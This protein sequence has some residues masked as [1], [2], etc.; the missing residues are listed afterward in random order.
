[1][2]KQCSHSGEHT[3]VVTEWLSHSYQTVFFTQLLSHSGCQCSSHIG[4]QTLV[5]TQWLAHSACHTE[6]VTQWSAHSHWHT[7]VGTQWLA[8]SS[9]HAVVRH[10][11][12]VENLK[13]LSFIVQLMGLKDFSVFFYNNKVSNRPANLCN[14][15]TKVHKVMRFH[16]KI[17]VP[18]AWSRP[19]FCLY[20]ISLND[21]LQLRIFMWRK[22]AD[23][24]VNLKSISSW[25]S[26]AQK[27][28][29]IFEKKLP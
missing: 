4:H 16:C 27:T 1:M 23:A 7:V 10:M 9:H 17:I 19:M 12:I 26:I 28:N 25:N 22:P 11:L 2:V 15:W 21:K 14:V 8:H 5:V 29:E 6:V 24:S 18:P 3:V 13:Y 20:L